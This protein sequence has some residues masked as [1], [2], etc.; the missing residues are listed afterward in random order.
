MPSSG[1]WAD[2]SVYLWQ[3]L[4]KALTE[5]ILDMG[6]FVQER[7]VLSSSYSIWSCVFSLLLDCLCWLQL[8]HSSADIFPPT[9]A[10][11]LPAC[12]FV[13]P[14][15]VSGQWFPNEGISATILGQYLRYIV[16]PPVYFPGNLVRPLSY[17]VFI[18]LASGRELG[19][20]C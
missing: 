6:F 13:L 12:S 7:F 11:P 5:K 8:W 2:L 19:W 3:S 17:P 9:L 10:S 16:A 4:A 18:F 14:T 15:P 20:G 1:T